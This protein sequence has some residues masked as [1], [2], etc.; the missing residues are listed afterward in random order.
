MPKVP[1]VEQGHH[2]V[3]VGTTKSR[4]GLEIQQKGHRVEKSSLLF[5]IGESR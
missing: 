5:K 2:R 1:K 4:K 3:I